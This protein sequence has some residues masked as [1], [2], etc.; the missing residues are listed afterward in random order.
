MWNARYCLIQNLL[1]TYMRSK[2]VRIIIHKAV[3]LLVV[4]CGYNT[5]SVLLT[6]EHR[7]RVFRNWVLRGGHLGLRGRK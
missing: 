4:L 5:W 7:M 6:K 3:I 2:S 1:F